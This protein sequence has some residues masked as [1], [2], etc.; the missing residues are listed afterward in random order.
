MTD[1]ETEDQQ[2]EDLKKWWQENGRAVIVGVLIGLAALFGWRGWSSY[3]Q[4]HAEA[5]S[6]LYENTFESLGAKRYDEV[7]T[8]GQQLLD[9]YGNTPYA[10]MAALAMARAAVDSKDYAA[11]ETHLQW[12]KSHA[13]QLDITYIASLRLVQVLLEQAKYADAEALLNESYPESYA[14]QVAEL[15]GDAYVLQGEQ[16][17]AR[18]AYEAALTTAESAARQNLEMKLNDLAKPVDSSVS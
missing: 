13:H 16:D 14:A 12:A 1:F 2:L 8:A 15:R 5:A 4:Q 18:A 3:Q 11:A 7:K 9:D 6:S 17:K 10:D